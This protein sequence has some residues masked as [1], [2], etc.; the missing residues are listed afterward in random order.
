MP[1]LFQVAAKGIIVRKGAA[2]ILRGEVR[3]GPRAGEQLWDLPG[4]RLETNET[5]EE[6]LMR[7]LREELPEI[8]HVATCQLIHVCRGFHLE[9]LRDLIVLYFRISADPKIKRLSAEHVEYRWVDAAALRQLRQNP[10]EQFFDDMGAA[11]EIA[12]R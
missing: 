8:G 3:H 1:H 5:P 2:L 12:L 6:G 7:E 10:Q 11:V 4:G 9:A